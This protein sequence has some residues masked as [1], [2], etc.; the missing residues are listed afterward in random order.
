[1]AFHRE[2]RTVQVQ[3]DVHAQ[4]TTHELSADK[5]APGTGRCVSR[6][7]SGCQ[8]PSAVARIRMR[9]GRSSLDADEISV[10]V[11]GLTDRSNSIVAAGNVQGTRNTPVGRRWDRGGTRADGPGDAQ[12]VPRLLTA[13]SGVMLTSTQRG[14][15]RRNAARAKAMPS[16]CTLRM[17]HGNPASPAGGKREHPGSRARRM[18]EHLAG[19]AESQSRKRCA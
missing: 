16:K 17:I 9:K 18:A 8:R 3:G 1:M 19:R 2:S 7:A 4:Q 12:N 5:L 10:G 11:D 6:A 13:A 15:R 14:C